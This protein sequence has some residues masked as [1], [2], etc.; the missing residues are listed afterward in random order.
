MACAQVSKAGNEPDRSDGLPA[1]FRELLAQFTSHLEDETGRSAHTVRGYLGD[2][3]SLLRYAN[4]CGV[5]SVSDMDIKVLRGWL[6]DRR[7]QG[8]ARASLA[9]QVSAARTFTGWA[10]RAGHTPL[11]PGL[12]LAGPKVPHNPPQ[13]LR[14]D[15]A[16]AVVATVQDDRSPA[17][18][19]DWAVLE[20]LYATGIRVAELCG[21]DLDSVDLSRNL[22]RVF[23][24]GAKERTV[25]FGIPAA[26]AVDDYLQSARPLLANDHSGSALLLGIRGGRL[27]PSSVRR[28]VRV[29]LSKAGVPSLTPHGLRHS[30]ATHLLE[31]GADLRSV[32]ELLGH[33]SIDSTQIYTHVSAERLRGAFTQAHPR[34]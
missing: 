21:L 17:G 24:K 13:V 10:H 31:G 25:P 19:R 22:V 3:R 12:R 5:T 26:R 7:R 29:W 9:R 27:H 16:E 20:L 11:D 30:A 8:A 34:A 23:G 1:P 32:Q 18:I 2:V 28:L 14:V 4:D 33:A 6:A 15:Q